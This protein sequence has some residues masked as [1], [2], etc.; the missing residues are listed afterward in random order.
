MLG[1]IDAY[2]IAKLYLDAGNHYFFKK[3]NNELE[4]NDNLLSTALNAYYNFCEHDNTS[5]GYNRYE[6]FLLSIS[7]FYD[8]SEQININ[9]FKEKVYYT[10]DL[11]ETENGFDETEDILGGFI[12]ENSTHLILYNDGALPNKELRINIANLFIDYI[13]EM[14][15]HPITPFI[16]VDQIDIYCD[17]YVYT[18]MVKVENQNLRYK[19]NVL[20]DEIYYFNARALN[21]ESTISCVIYDC[22]GNVVEDDFIIYDYGYENYLVTQLEVGSY[23][24][25]IIFDNEFENE[26]RIWIEIGP[27]FSDCRKE[28]IVDETVNVMEHLHNDFAQYKFM[29]GEEEYYNLNIVLKSYDYELIPYCAIDIIDTVANKVDTFYFDGGSPND[30]NEYIHNLVFLASPYIMINI[31]V[32][33]DDLFLEKCHIKISKLSI[34]ELDTLSSKTFNEEIDM[35]NLLYCWN[36]NQTSRYYIEYA[37]ESFDNILFVV[38]KKNDTGFEIIEEY[39]RQGH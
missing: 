34:V 1:D 37:F 14:S 2:N 16:E 19:F 20:C 27:Y 7:N 38:M 26:M 33:S 32:S 25:D 28:I 8:D 4:I 35:G 30:F 11:V 10:C 39:F 13:L 22:N 18:D 3:P 36:V 23:Y 12:K 15:S 21:Y 6:M 17:S 24:F 5:A 29:M 9:K 31:N